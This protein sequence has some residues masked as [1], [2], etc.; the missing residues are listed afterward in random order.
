MGRESVAAFF[1]FDRTLIEVESG[2]VG[3]E[4]LRR[5]GMLP[6]RFLLRVIGFSYLYRMRLISNERMVRVML[7]FYRGRRL[8]DFEEG[9]ETF[10]RDY[11]RPHLAPAV[12]ERVNHHRKEGHLLVLISGSIRYMLAPVATDLG[13]DVL[14]CTDIAVGADGLLTGRSE[15]EICVGEAK[16]R[17]TLQLAEQRGLDL[18]RS[19]AYGNDMADV[20]LLEVVGYPRVVEPDASLRRIARRRAWPILSY[21]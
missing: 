11:L 15:G 20:N 19:Y 2:R 9:A 1:D 7:T 8:I 5:H 16:R 6:A 4:W 10:Y 14:F 12:V 17:L 18:A 21:R 3:M 13:F